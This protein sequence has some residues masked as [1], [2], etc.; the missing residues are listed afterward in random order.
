MSEGEWFGLENLLVAEGM[1]ADILSGDFT[2]LY[3]LSNQTFKDVLSEPE[4][5][6]DYETYCMLRDKLTMT[7]I[8]DEI[9][10]KCISCGSKSHSIDSCPLVTYVPN[11]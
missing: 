8:K 7:L 3:C 11:R 2:I 1:H 6:E 5:S 10:I 4:F 9:V